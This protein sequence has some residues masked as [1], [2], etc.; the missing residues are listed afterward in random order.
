TI[1]WFDRLSKTLGS[2]KSQKL[3]EKNWYGDKV[4]LTLISPL[5][6]CT[7]NMLLVFFSLADE[8]ELGLWFVIIV[9]NACLL[10]L[11]VW[12]IVKAKKNLVFGG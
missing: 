9:G 5:C 8:I 10:I 12:K 1:E 6:L 2:K 3:S 7:N 4:F 11:Q